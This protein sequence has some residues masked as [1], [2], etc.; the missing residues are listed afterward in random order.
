MVLY[1]SRRCVRDLKSETSKGSER[2][3][4]QIEH[5]TDSVFVIVELAI[6]QSKMGLDT[7]FF[8]NDLSE[9]P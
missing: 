6:T 7:E 4:Y 8:L 1:G 2:R 3:L 5:T 9:C